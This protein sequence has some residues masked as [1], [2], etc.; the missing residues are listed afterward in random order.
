MVLDWGNVGVDVKIQKFKVG[1]RGMDGSSHNREQ[2]T[3]SIPPEA[4]ERTEKLDAA[5]PKLLA[6]RHGQLTKD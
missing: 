1:G 3:T 4:K 5:Q 6:L 2:T